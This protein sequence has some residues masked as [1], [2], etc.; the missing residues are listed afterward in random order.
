MRAEWSEM[1]SEP[2][3]A[4]LIGMSS[5]KNYSKPP[6]VI[7]Y[8]GIY[9]L[10]QGLIG[11]AFGIFLVV[12]EAQ[13]FHDPTAKI[14]GYGTALWFFFIFGAVAVCGYFLYRGR[15]WGRGPVV[16]LQI[17]LVPVA[18]YMFRSGR[19]ELAVPTT[20]VLILGLALLFNPTAINWWTMDHY[21]D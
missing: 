19:P 10:I 18:Y 14:S 11:I 7:Q 17:C 20:L 8:A 1:G 9:G 6:T 4:R 5:P 3:K 21:R 15:S 13:G 12:R 16:M 2:A